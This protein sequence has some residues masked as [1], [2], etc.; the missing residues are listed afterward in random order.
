MSKAFHSRRGA[1]VIPLPPGIASVAV[2]PTRANPVAAVA[3]AGIVAAAAALR[4]ATLDL[5]SFWVDEGATVHLLRSDFAG[6]LDGLTVTEKTPPLYYLLAWLWTR[7]FGTGE[8][9]V[10]SLSALIGVLTIPAAYALARELVSERAALITAAL[11]A[12][13]PLLVWYSQE[14]R[15]YA[16]L[17]LLATLATLFAVRRRVWLWALCSAL[18]LATHYFAAFVVGPLALWLLLRHADRRRAAAAAGA[19]AVAGLALLP[20]AIDQSG[21]PGSNFITG[22]G[23]G[24]RL[25]QVPK[26]FLL[27]YDAPAEAV[28]TTLA[29]ALAAAGGWLALTRAGERRAGRDGALAAAGDDGALTA[30]GDEGALT[31]GDDGALAGPAAAAGLA[32]A[33]IAL[34]LAAAAGGADFVIAR[35]L[36]VAL[37]PLIVV[38]AAGFAAAGRVGIGLAAA[39]AAVSLAT[40]LAVFS[41]PEFQRDDWRGAAEAIGPSSGERALVVNPI[42]GRVALSVYLDHLEP[43]GEQRR[44]VDEIVLVAVTERRPGETPRPPRPPNPGI[45]GFAVEARREADTFTLVRMRALNVQ[46]LG[47]G[48]LTYNRLG[49]DLA[50]TLRQPPPR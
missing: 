23:L 48:G 12:V 13:N 37:V 4:F 5:Q 26:Q 32:V 8:V 6:M 1:E 20:L 17:V 10:R 19:V 49:R 45:P 42:A 36:I 25:L 29:V 40:V 30:T 9:G 34:A 46:E 21:N 44:R 43:F 14:S 22:T 47:S 18:A 39:L 11:V 31:A 16:L 50:V 41:R 33:A 7:P 2:T 24:T 28:V 38:V 15:A 35:N 3:F 27:G